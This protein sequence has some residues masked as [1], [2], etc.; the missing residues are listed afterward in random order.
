MATKSVYPF[1]VETTNPSFLNN[2]TD[3][4]VR[5]LFLFEHNRENTSENVYPSF[6]DFLKRLNRDDVDTE[7]YYFVSASNEPLT[8]DEI[9]DNDPY[10]EVAN[11]L[12]DE[13]DVYIDAWTT[14]NSDEEGR[15]VARV[16]LTNG[17]IRWYNEQARFSRRV[18]EAID[19]VFDKIKTG[20][21]HTED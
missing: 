6:E 16:D 2:L 19:E 12:V 14:L 4:Q 13:D 1:S 8:E 3:T 21:Y 15:N 17:E 7:N 18:Q 11:S 10:A 5:L 9:N 20:Y